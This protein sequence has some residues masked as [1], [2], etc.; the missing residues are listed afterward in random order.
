MKKIIFGIALGLLIAPKAGRE[1]IKDVKEKVT[2]LIDDPEKAKEKVILVKDKIKNTD[3]EVVKEIALAKIEDVKSKI[4]NGV[5]LEKVKDKIDDLKE[6]VNSN[7]HVQGLKETVKKEVN[8]F[9]SDD[10][11]S[12]LFNDDEDDTFVGE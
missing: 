5:D 3:P 2:D 11:D 6:L 4:E 10:D 12:Y 8:K 7:P 1:L 9:S